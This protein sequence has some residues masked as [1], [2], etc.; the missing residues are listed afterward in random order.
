[1]AFDCTTQ[2][3]RS[4]VMPAG[5]IAKTNLLGELKGGDPRRLTVAP[6]H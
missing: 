6:C 2:D 3:W 1:M 4:H 5:S